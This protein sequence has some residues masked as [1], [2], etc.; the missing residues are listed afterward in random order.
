MQ[1]MMLYHHKDHKIYDAPLIQIKTTMAHRTAS[2]KAR[3]V[4]A[5]TLSALAAISHVSDAF[6]PSHFMKPSSQG[7]Y[8]PSSHV[9]G[10]VTH[11]SPISTSLSMSENPLEEMDD[12]RRSNLLQSLLR[13]LQIEGVP[14]LGCGKFLCV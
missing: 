9:T 1:K 3:A 12:E 13:D 5:A 6:S 2:F 4:I 14:L 11:T 7:I 10:T 8:R